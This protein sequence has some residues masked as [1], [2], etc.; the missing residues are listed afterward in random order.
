ML[1]FGCTS[2]EDTST[3]D[4]VTENA[5]SEN[6]QS[7]QSGTQETEKTATTGSSLS[8]ILKSK[9][10]KYTAEYEITA[11]GQKQ[12]WI[13]SYDLPNFATVVK[14]SEGESRMIFK[15]STA[16]VCTDENGEWM[17]LKLATIEPNSNDELESD[18]KEG[19]VEPVY[20]GT[21][22]RAGLT[23][24]KY[25][26]VSEGKESTVCYTKKGI[27]LEMQSEDMTMVATK[28]S[29]SVDSKLFVLPAEPQDMGDLLN[30]NNIPSG[31]QNQDITDMF[32]DE[33]TE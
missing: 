28:V 11:E 19:D 26:I 33:V 17:C 2:G 25:S 32:P 20:V 22:S 16:Y 3:K 1:L 27:V 31:D 12:T 30:M 5:N 4:E 29:D 13:Q 8:D 6:Q 18:V 15:D 10:L 21:C 7:E 24:E 9:S 23:G 14:T